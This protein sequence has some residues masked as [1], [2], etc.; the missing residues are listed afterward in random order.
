MQKR[1]ALVK[2][3][4][5]K[6]W[7]SLIP[8]DH[9]PQLDAI[10]GNAKALEQAIPFPCKKGPLELT[11][12]RRGND[13]GKWMVSMTISYS[14]EMSCESV[15]R[16]LEGTGFVECKATPEHMRLRT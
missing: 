8:A 5:R 15:R 7:V 11:Q 4:G 16:F 1:Y 14:K 2:G 13:R 10:N 12:V 6:V 3:P 9:V